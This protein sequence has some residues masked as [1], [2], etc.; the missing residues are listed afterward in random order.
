MPES[1]EKFCVLILGSEILWAF[2]S[3]HVCMSAFMRFEVSFFKAC[4]H[5]ELCELSTAHTHP[6][7]HPHTHTLTKPTALK[8]ELM[9]G[10]CRDT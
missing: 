6:P 7:T 8:Y 2:M 5:T 1:R 3:V 4:W 10:N 9:P